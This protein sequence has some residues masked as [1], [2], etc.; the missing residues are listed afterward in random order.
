MQL[1]A[2]C[3]APCR[4]AVV[5]V[6][7]GGGRHC[8]V[9]WSPREAARP[10]KVN[11]GPSHGRHRVRVSGSVQ[12]LSPLAWWAL[13]VLGKSLEPI[14]PKQLLA[15]RSARLCSWLWWERLQADPARPVE[16]CGR[17]PGTRVRRP[18]VQ[19]AQF[20]ASYIWRSVRLYSN[21]SCWHFSVCLLSEQ[22]PTECQQK[23]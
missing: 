23:C 20:S 2:S 17:Y 22:R 7:L 21:C 9:P 16:G 1:N 3:L 4:L 19:E 14:R 6:R 5:V 15:G 13:F 18:L 8:H 10:A 12:R 11:T